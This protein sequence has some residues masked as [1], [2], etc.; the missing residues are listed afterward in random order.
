MT[1]LGSASPEAGLAGLG[2]DLAPS[3]H[4]R[5]NLGNGR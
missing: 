4:G 3:D 1:G 5:G 2:L